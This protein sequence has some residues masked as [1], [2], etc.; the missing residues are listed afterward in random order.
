M[1]REKDRIQFIGMGGTGVK[2]WVSV[3]D[4]EISIGCGYAFVRVS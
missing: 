2:S 4:T 1:K 3:T